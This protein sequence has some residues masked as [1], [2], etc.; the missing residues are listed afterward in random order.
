[1]TLLRLTY[2]IRTEQFCLLQNDLRGFLLPVRRI[3]I[4]A[5][6]VADEDADLGLGAFAQR[7]VNRHAFA[8]V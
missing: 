2:P 5:E 6:D 8:N 7:P 3:T 1:M 4:S